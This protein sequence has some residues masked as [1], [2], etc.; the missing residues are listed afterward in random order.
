MFVGLY[1]RQL[2]RFARGE[3][4]RVVRLIVI[5]EI[6]VEEDCSIC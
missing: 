4:E 2:V 6:T 5:V 3:V 1:V